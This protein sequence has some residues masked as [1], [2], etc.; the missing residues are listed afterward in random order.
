V[1]SVQTREGEFDLGLGTGCARDMEP[2]A[3]LGDVVQQCGL[4]DARLA[5]QHDDPALTPAGSLD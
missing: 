4:A 5:A 2:G 1:A 3:A